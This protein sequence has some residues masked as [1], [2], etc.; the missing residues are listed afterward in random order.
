MAVLEQLHQNRCDRLVLTNEQQHPVGLINLASLLGHLTVAQLLEPFSDEYQTLFGRSAFDQSAGGRS[1]LNAPVRSLQPPVIESLAVLPADWTLSQ[2]SAHLQTHLQ[3][4]TPLLAALVDPNG[5]FLGLLNPVALLEYWITSEPLTRS[6][7]NLGMMNQGQ[8][9][10]IL[11]LSRQL[12]AQR[13]ELE[14]R[15]KVQQEEISHLRMRVAGLLVAGSM[16]VPHLPVVRPSL[17]SHLT[18][19]NALLELLERLPLPLM[20]QTSSGQVLAQNSVWRTQV[21]ELSD[22]VQIRQEAAIWLEGEGAESVESER[23]PLCHLGAAPDTCVCTCPLKNG[24]EQIVQFVKI[25]LGTLLP[26]WNLAW[27]NPSPS[28]SQT[29][30]PQPFNPQHQTLNTIAATTES[31]DH[32]TPQTDPAFRLATLLSNS[33]DNSNNLSLSTSESGMESLWLVLAQDMTEQQQLAKELTAK[34]ADLVQLNRLKDEFLAC[35]SH[36]LKTPLTAVLGLSS[37]LKDQTLGSL[38]QRQVHYAQLIYQSSRHLM[39]VVNDILD[40]T[41]IETGQLELSFEPVNIAK[42]CQRAFDQAKQGRLLE[43]KTDESITEDN[44]MAQFSLEIEPG[45]EF[46]IADEM[47]L[48][49]MMVHLLSNALKFTEISHL[50]GLKVSRWGGWIAFTVW[51][52]GIGIPAEKQHL[53]F[54]KFQQL[55]NPLIREF[56][57]V[58]LG[59]VLTR[60]L[61]RLHGGDV[62]F[63]SKEAQGSQFTI[64]LPPTPPA[65]TQLLR[66][67]GLNEVEFAQEKP[68]ISWHASYPGGRVPLHSRRPPPDPV[69]QQNPVPPARINRSRLILIVEA[70]PQAIESLT[71]KLTGLGYRVV[72]ARSGTEALEKAR[73]LQPC[74]IFLNPVLP[75]LSGWDVLTLLKSNLETQRL[76]IVLTTTGIDGEQ[77]QG[78]ADGFLSLPV[79]TKALQQTLQQILVEAEDLNLQCYGTKNSDAVGLT[80]LRICFANQTGLESSFSQDLG[81]FLQLRRYRLLEANDLEQAELLARVWKPNVI[82]LD[83]PLPNPRVD[84]QQ[85]SYYPFLAALPIITLDQNT[86]QAANQIS[87][88][89]VFPCLTQGDPQREP[90]SLTNDSPEF[91]TLLQVI[92]IA[93]GCVW[94]PSILAVDISTLPMSLEGMPLE[95]VQVE[96]ALHWVPQES[97]WLQALAQYL[98]TAGFRALLGRSWQEVQQ[99]VQSEST[100]LLLICWTNPAPRPEVMEML[101]M[102]KSLAVKLPII[103]LDHREYDPQVAEGPLPLP[104]LLREIATQ[105]L[106]P[107]MS[108]TELLDWIHRLL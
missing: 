83:N 78:Q 69:L 61:A 30:N 59:L 99:Q 11:Q 100:D 56:E 44:L 76:P 62:T 63:L 67:E 51:D 7:P 3:T 94:Q 43:N 74:A 27:S 19:V 101:E 81:Y 75:L 31:P 16:P 96:Q 18:L 49:Q 88:L 103:V 34:N 13:A 54:Q 48:R 80:I 33:P 65:K 84:L 104:P 50:V 45:L 40:L 68:T 23:S 8:Q 102:L 5:Q 9:H 64:L 12:L 41:R 87:G 106:T 38:N 66:G 107:P 95:E 92:Q 1:V 35:I 20:L 6:N 85:L 24:R 47:R 58:G 70:V 17:P 73:R 32:Q 82:L 93:A 90:K 28:P 79:Q 22:P 108:M 98:Q 39:A 10:Q 60:H 2:L 29:P 52:Q 97:E 71:D 91:A 57:G 21:G 55:E 46:L 37:L 14:Q 15:I 26:N 4:Q 77:I 72:V 86:T 89:L 25:S 105:V 36:E 53:I 42:V